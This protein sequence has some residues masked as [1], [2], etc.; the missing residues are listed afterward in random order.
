MKKMKTDSSSNLN[1]AKSAFDK[2]A[3]VNVAMSCDHLC[4]AFLLAIKYIL[5][6]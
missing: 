4:Y 3:E 5:F 2:P 6:S 1:K